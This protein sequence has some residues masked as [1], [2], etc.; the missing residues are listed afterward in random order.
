MASTT[1]QMEKERRDSL[2]RSL[3][4][5]HDFYCVRVLAGLLI[6]HQF[7]VQRFDTM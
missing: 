6:W 5:M 1:P 3:F 7:S 4:L 2:M